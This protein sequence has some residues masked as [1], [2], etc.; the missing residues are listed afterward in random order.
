MVIGIQ[1]VKL[2]HRSSYYYKPKEKKTRIS[3]SGIHDIHVY[4][5]F[6]WCFSGGRETKNKNQIH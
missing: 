1:G 6:R 4:S 2:K 5:A 3:L